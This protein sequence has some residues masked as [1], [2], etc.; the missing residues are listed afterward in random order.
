[1]QHGPS[2]VWCLDGTVSVGAFQNGKQYGAAWEWHPN[3]V[4]FEHV[5]VDGKVNP[6]FVQQVKNKKTTTQQSVK[7]TQHNPDGSV[8]EF[9]SLADKIA[10]KEGTA[11]PMW[12]QTEADGFKVGF[13]Q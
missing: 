7:C 3:G 12:T 11:R 4:R 6:P 2:T 13:L 8:Y 9:A 5:Y 1:M 10:L